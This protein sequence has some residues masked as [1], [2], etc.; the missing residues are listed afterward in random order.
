MGYSSERERIHEK[1]IG[2]AL[3][4]LGAIGV[5][6]LAPPSEVVGV[7]ALVAFLLALTQLK[8][9]WLYYSLYTFALVLALAAP[10]Q[11]ASEVKQRGSEIL[12]GMI[13][14]AILQA[15][16]TRLSRD[17]PQPELLAS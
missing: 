10:A 3:G 8:T 17:D 12:I 16:A 9:Y 14:L 15:V 1:A 13:A 6:I 11:V 7:I 2:T 4:A 5:A